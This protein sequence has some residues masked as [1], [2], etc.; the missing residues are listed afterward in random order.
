MPKIKIQ[1]G[2]FQSASG[3]PLAFGYATF[4]L[5]VDAMADD[6]QISAGRIIRLPLDANG[7]L[8]GY[9]W[10]NDQMEPNNTVYIAR[11]YT[12]QGQFVWESQLYITSPSGS[13]VTEEVNDV[14][15]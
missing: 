1:G 14:Y 7:N 13:F 2:N 10:P 12:A 6:V 3:A 8:S 4:R 5:S 9:I 15:I 11:A